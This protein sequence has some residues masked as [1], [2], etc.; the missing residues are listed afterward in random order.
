MW[1]P[2]DDIT[3]KPTTIPK[4]REYLWHRESRKLQR[5][6]ERERREWIATQEDQ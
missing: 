6:D 2:M 1:L 4:W 5:Q 3:Y